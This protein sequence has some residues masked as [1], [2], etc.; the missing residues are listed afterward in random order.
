GSSDGRA[1]ASVGGGGWA[2]G[3]EGG[4]EGKALPAATKEK[5][6]GSSGDG[7]NGEE[8]ERPPVLSGSVKTC[9]GYLKGYGVVPGDS[10]G[11]APK[12]VQ[13]DWIKLNCD[14][15]LG[16]SGF[17]LDD[18]PSGGRQRAI[19]VVWN[20]IGGWLEYLRPT[21]VS[22]AIETCGTECIFTN[23]RSLLTR[24]D[25][26]FFHAPTFKMRDAFPKVKPPGVDYVFAN[27]EPTTY[28]PVESLLRNKQVMSQFDLKMTYERDSD[29]PLGYV[30]SSSTARYFKAPKIAFQEKDGFGTPDAI[31]AF[32]SNCKAAGAT[33]R[34]K[35]ME[36]LMHH[37]TVHSFGYCLHNREE[38]KLVPG[39]GAISRLENKVVLL[40]R[41][42]FFLAFENNNQLKDYVTEKVYNGL[43]SGT[44]PVYW[45]AE[46]I[47]DFVPKGSVVK[48]SD[49]SSPAEL[50]KHLKM[51][52]TNE[53]A[54]EEYFRWRN[55]PE[56]EKRFEQV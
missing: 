46:N 44:L 10:W 32:V 36:E 34:V 17:N 28:R 41:Y 29:V 39:E 15:V 9:D 3:G 38:P 54:Y 53:Q 4:D 40:S 12:R 25:G 24:A 20:E 50:G 1:S 52:A 45:G 49:F 55:D 43:Q 8:D 6:G 7:P 2:L 51:L 27:L 14:Q 26:V 31:A 13:D 19:V 37:V 47:E 56:E 33:N 30:G 22:G 35:Y 16:M 18:P 11:T 21:F 23:D 5:G 42:K 48:A